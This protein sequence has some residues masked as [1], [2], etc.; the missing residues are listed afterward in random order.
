MRWSKFK[1]LIQKVVWTYE[2]SQYQLTLTGKQ[3]PPV[4]KDRKTILKGLKPSK[5]SVAY[6]LP[7]PNLAWHAKTAKGWTYKLENII[8]TSLLITLPWAFPKLTLMTQI[9]SFSS[10]GNIL[11]PKAPSNNPHFQVPL[12]NCHSMGNCIPV[13]IDYLPNSPISIHW[14]RLLDEYPNTHIGIRLTFWTN[15]HE[16]E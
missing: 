8:P 11:K 10:K 16:H 15:N 5:T 4:S 1:I 14:N 9:L 12:P 2:P 6:Y 3:V 13:M 7:R